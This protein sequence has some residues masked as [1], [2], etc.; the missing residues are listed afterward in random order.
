MVE[1]Q[2]RNASRRGY[3]VE[4][5]VQVLYHRIRAGYKFRT[6][7]LLTGVVDDMADDEQY[8]RIEQL[9]LDNFFGTTS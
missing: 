6:I 9:V 8:E 2:R 3:G 7:S 4:L 5:G 1:D